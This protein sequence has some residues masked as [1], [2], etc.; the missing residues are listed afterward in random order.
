MEL[1]NCT[2]IHRRINCARC[3]IRYTNAGAGI[4][5][6]EA[7]IRLSQ[8]VLPGMLKRG[9]GQIVNIGSVFG[10]LAFPHFSVYS[11]YLR[12]LAEQ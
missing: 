1:C 6:L 12:P 10:A 7:P 8:A 5:Y 2:T 9:T 3:N 4:F 11:A